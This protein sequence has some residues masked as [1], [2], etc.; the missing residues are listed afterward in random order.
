MW[1]TE[2]TTHLRIGVGIR[3]AAELDDGVGITL[4]DR[5]QDLVVV[6]SRVPS[7]FVILKSSRVS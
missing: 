1:T 2:D 5:F 4:D 3:I 6:C 7:C